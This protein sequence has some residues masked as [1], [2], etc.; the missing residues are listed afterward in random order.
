MWLQLEKKSFDLL[1]H[2][3]LN[4]QVADLLKENVISIDGTHHQKQH[5]F[6]RSIKPEKFNHISFKKND[7]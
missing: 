4:S 5:H 7:P 3:I 6:L 1:I 2:K